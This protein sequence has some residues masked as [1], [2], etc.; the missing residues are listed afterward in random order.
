MLFQALKFIG[1][2]LIFY[3]IFLKL[4]IQNYATYGIVQSITI[5]FT[6][7]IGFN[8]KSSFQKVYSKKL[9][10]RTSNFVILI[11]LILGTVLFSIVFWIINTTGFTNLI[12][13]NSDNIPRSHLFYL[14]SILFCFKEILSS[15]LNAKK[16]TFLYGLSIVLPFFISIPAIVTSENLEINK[17]LMIITTS[18]FVTVLIVAINNRSFFSY[19]SY[20][21]SH[22]K[23]IL[24]YIF[25]YTSLSIPTLSSKYL[26]DVV[27]RSVLLSTKGELAV[28]ILTFASSIFA[29]FRSIEQGFF[30]AIT[31]YIL[32]NDEKKAIKLTIA[33]KLIFLQ[34]IF[35]IIFFALS[36]IWIETLKL[37]FNNKPNEVF[38]PII[39]IVMSFSTVVSYI[40]NYLLSN[41]KKHVRELRKFYI[42][43][44]IVNLMMLSSIIIV[45]LSALTFVLIQLSF[46][47]LNLILVRL[48]ISP[49]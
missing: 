37:I 35:T 21:T 9:I 48:M 12:F 20:S 14:Y 11:I 40:K 47:T 38:V 46:M 34:S 22:H 49:K 45:N 15:I 39:L 2:V 18:Y 23:L 3:L 1:S 16:K 26:L 24:G 13:N 19:K 32:L 7:L 10:S 25:N 44:T 17:L 6:L 28:A 5:L 30:K 36:P 31:P 8:I 42:I 43:S 41:V 29:V 27:A 4:D 33:K